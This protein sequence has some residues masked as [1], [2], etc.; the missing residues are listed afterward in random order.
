MSA[1]AAPAP[2]AAPAPE[3]AALDAA[4]GLKMFCSI[5]MEDL[6]GEPTSKLLKTLVGK[7]ASIK[8]L[9]WL[10]KLARLTD[11]VQENIP[12]KIEELIKGQSPPRELSLTHASF[13]LWL[14]ATL[15]KCTKKRKDDEPSEEE[16]GAELLSDRLL[17]LMYTAIAAAVLFSKCFSWLENDIEKVD[18]RI[19]VLS[20][21]V[22]D[23]AQQEMEEL[24][25]VKGNMYGFYGDMEN[26]GLI[27]KNTLESI[28]DGNVKAV[29][30]A[31]V[32]GNFQFDIGEDPE[33]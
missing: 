16:V 19:D 7:T 24:E 11:K 13:V 20:G 31:M 15:G 23:K 3:V 25:E 9:N 4:T 2:A 18:N 26:L 1:Q 30:D 17:D 8:K 29:M 27:H 33:L 6:E 21:K 10:F 14:K 12:E 22:S 32:L 5:A 28:L